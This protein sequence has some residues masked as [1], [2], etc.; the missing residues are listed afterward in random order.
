MVDTNSTLAGALWLLQLMNNSLRENHNKRPVSYDS[1]QPMTQKKCL[2]RERVIEQLTG[3]NR[4]GVYS[5]LFC[6][7]LITEAVFWI[8]SITLNAG[9]SFV[10]ERRGSI[11]GQNI[12]ML[13]DLVTIFDSHM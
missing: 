6:P 9:R 7:S 10:N 4:L 11:G 3:V 12:I 13:G 8:N 2:K 5:T 1:F